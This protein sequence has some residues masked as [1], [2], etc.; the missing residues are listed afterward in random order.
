MYSQN[1]SETSLPCAPPAATINGKLEVLRKPHLLVVRESLSS[2]CLFEITSSIYS[3]DINTIKVK[4]AL[5]S[6]VSNLQRHVF[7]TFGIRIH[8][9]LIIT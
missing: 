2:Y 7:I 9:C 1:A 3:L 6:I 4:Y 8:A 5:R